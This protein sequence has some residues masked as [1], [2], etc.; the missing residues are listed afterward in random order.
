MYSGMFPVWSILLP[1]LFMAQL[2]LQ[3]RSG[4]PWPTHATQQLK[5]RNSL[6]D[7]RVENSYNMLHL[8][9]KNDPRQTANQKER[10]EWAT[11]LKVHRWQSRLWA[12]GHVWNLFSS[13]MDSQVFFFVCQYVTCIPMSMG[14][15]IY[16]Q[17]QRTTMGI[18]SCLFCLFVCLF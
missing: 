11:K 3:G 12:S 1:G 2:Q 7:L 5:L 17:S 6:F 16:L 9:N 8:L 18:A 10:P 13:L 15:H 4:K 14:L